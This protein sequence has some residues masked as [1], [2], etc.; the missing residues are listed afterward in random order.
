MLYILKIG[1]SVCTEKDE[2]NLQAKEETIQRIAREIKQAMENKRFQLILV[3]GAGPFG[4]KLVT[5]FEIDNGLKNEEDFAKFKKVQ[6]SMKQL[7][8]IVLKEFEKEGVELHPL[9]PHEVIRQENKKIT[10]FDTQILGQFLSNGKIPTLY[11]D[12]VPD[13]K[14][15]GSVVSGDSIIAWLSRELKADT[16]FLGTDVDGIYS[17]DPKKDSNAK[18]F[19][20]INESNWLA[21][22]KALDE[23][24]TVDVT[25]GMK[26]KIEKMREKFKGGKV[27][28]FDANKEES[29]FKAL[30]GQKIG[31]LI[32]F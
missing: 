1:G 32:E 18:R 10:S 30:T 2:N 19:D 21:V 13:S 15:K 7:N 11:G 4:H 31:T 24:S 22:E 23:A 5:D 17:A 27:I 29:V 8:G 14:L 6:E 3:H 26:G 12:M 20:R 25:G 28:V 16:V 9:V